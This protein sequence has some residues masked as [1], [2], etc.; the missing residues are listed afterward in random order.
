MNEY[1]YSIHGVGLRLTTDSPAIAGAVQVLLRHFQRE[2]LEGPVAL[3]I[4]FKGVHDRAEIPVTAS[5]SAEVL[6]AGSGKTAGDLLHSEW[7]CNLYRDGDRKIADFHEQGLLLI[8]DQRGRVEG[9]L[10]EPDAMHLDVR[11]S[12]FHFAL[13]E[14]LKR[15]G[16]YTIHATALEKGGR[17]LLIPGA[18][19]RGKTTSCISLLRAGYRCLSDDHPLLRENG[20]GLEILSFPVKID[21][22]EKTIAFFPE[23]REA[24]GRLHQGVQKRYFFVED[25]YPHAKAD[26]CDPALI[27]FPRITD[28]PKSRVEPLP[29]SRALEEILPQG[30]LVFDKEVA[31]KQFQT[32]SRLVEKAAC[33]RLYFGED[34]LDL[35]Q[36]VDHL[37]SV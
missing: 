7:R 36:L 20:N 9:Y 21:V 16:L 27:I 35:P 18:S 1:F 34:I 17:G 23:L 26:I 28:M 12:F 37:L 10:V 11:I 2:T 3:E 31:R 29:K 5:P 8:E 13:T 6:F 19:G 30:L 33:Y 25:I 32:F 4:L 24:D 14:L 22:T 15:Q